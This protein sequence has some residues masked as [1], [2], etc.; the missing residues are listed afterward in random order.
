M[1]VIRMQSRRWYPAF[2]RAPLLMDSQKIIKHEVPHPDE[3][4]HPFY[5]PTR[6]EQFIA[7]AT[8]HN[9][10]L[11]D[12]KKIVPSMIQHP[13]KQNSML[14]D[15]RLEFTDVRGVNKWLL[16]FISKRQQQEKQVHKPLDKDTKF[17]Q[18]PYLSSSDIS[19]ISSLE[20]TLSSI[21]DT[22]DLESSIES[23][24]TELQNIFE[25]E[26]KQSKLFCEN[27]LVHL[28]NHHGN[29]VRKLILLINLTRVQLFSRLDQ[30]K[31]LDIVMYHTLCKIKTIGNLPYNVDLITTVE[32]LL[33][34]INDRFFPKRCED[35]LHPIV[36]EQLLSFFIE[37]GNLNESKI[38]L[39]HLIKKGILPNTGAING[40]LKSIDEHFGKNSNFVDMKSKFT[41][42]TDLAPI[43]QNHEVLSLFKFLIPMCRHF[44]ELYSLLNIIRKS[45]NAKQILDS[46]LSILI[47]KVPTFTNDPMVNSANL[48]TLLNLVTPLYEQNKSSEFVEKFILAFALQGNCTMMA[49][50]IDEYEIKLTHKRRMQITS[51]LAKN[52]KNHISRH[53]DAIGYNK[54]FKK[55]FLEKYI[56]NKTG[57]LKTLD[58]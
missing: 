58:S 45:D 29:S 56:F 28:I 30:L 27:I 42:I 46:T 8:E 16:D 55:Y 40:Y 48:C 37:S 33:T 52:E 31:A 26:D 15:S 49:N 44:D 57:E 23:V 1:C 4:L 50:M 51:A 17:S 3:I 38:F 10:S 39:S 21:E 54:E 36:M 22:D 25:R 32:S 2:K 20:D 41:F 18:I 7:C 11:L 53:T 12:G 47:K 43:I 13:T 9:P 34:T 24:N 14:V 6:I 35:A 19:R 5:Q